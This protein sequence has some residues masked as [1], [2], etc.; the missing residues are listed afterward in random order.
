M[1]SEGGEL[2]GPLFGGSRADAE[3][4]DRARLQAMLDAE[5]ALAAASARAGV[6]RGGRR[7]HRRLPPG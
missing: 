1:P 7:G 6:A 5:R 3:L 2:F 4:T